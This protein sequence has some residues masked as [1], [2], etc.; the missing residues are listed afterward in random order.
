MQ[1]RLN[2]LLPAI[3]ILLLE[4]PACL[5]STA[6]FQHQSN[7]PT[8]PSPSFKLAQTGD[9]SEIYSDESLKTF[10]DMLRLARELN[11]RPM[12]GMALVGIG[13][14]YVYQRKFTQAIDHLEPG[15][16]IA[17]EMNDRLSEKRAVMNL[18]VAYANIGQ[19]DK[20]T[21]YAQ[22][23]LKIAQQDNDL[24]LQGVALQSL[25]VAKFSQGKYQQ[26][27]PYYEQ[28]LQIFQ[29]VQ[30]FERAAI[31]ATG[32]SEVYSA[33]K[34]P[35]K[36]MEYLRLSQEL[37]KKVSS[38]FNTS[39]TLSDEAAKL[40]AIQPTD[41]WNV[42]VG[43]AISSRQLGRIDEAIAAFARYGEMFRTDP[44]AAQYS[45]IAQELTRQMR[46]LNLKGGVYIHQIAAGGSAAQKG[47]AVG[48]IV[49][50]YNGQPI[51]NMPEFV[52]A[53]D[54]APKDKPLEVTYLRLEGKQFRR[55]TAIMNHPMGAG[56]MPI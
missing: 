12:E 11:D 33:L 19:A 34:Q 13:S 47:L 17:R 14:T 9:A 44:T 54:R 1:S 29:Q 2:Y 25:G 31:V 3:G 36:A 5:P 8:S 46:S 42:V 49:I 28:S 32:L 39:Q 52:A 37:S 45:R 56:L 27:I 30:D 10:Q 53:R 51:S 18:S 7:P 15:L 20:T 16:K 22:E 24:P 26:V 50:S 23:L 41:P 38:R 35:D 4:L 40:L 43:K 6:S 48:D 21:L 55:Y